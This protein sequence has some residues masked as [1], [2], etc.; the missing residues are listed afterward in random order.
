MFGRQ[1]KI[2]GEVRLPTYHPAE[3]LDTNGSAIQQCLVREISRTGAYIIPDD[4]KTLPKNCEI[5]IPHFNLSVKATV[6][7]SKKGGAGLEFDKP[8]AASQLVQD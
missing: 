1:K 7:W 3:I 2:R 6:R 8:V 5:W 4:P